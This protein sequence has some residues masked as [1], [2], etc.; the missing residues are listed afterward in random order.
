MQRPTEDASYSPTPENQTDALPAGDGKEAISD[1]RL[2]AVF[3]GDGVPL[4][5]FLKT[6]VRGRD[7]NAA[8]NV[9]PKKTNR[10]PNQGQQKNDRTS[11]NET[12][13]PCVHFVPPYDPS[14][15]AR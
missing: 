10:Y 11:S 12:S 7:G 2:L 14:T 3:L 5:A 6:P 8:Q 15:V 4:G 1:V 9:E 13:Y